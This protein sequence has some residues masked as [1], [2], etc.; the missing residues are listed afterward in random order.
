MKVLIDG[1]EYTKAE[2]KT[3]SIGIAIT[4][5]NRNELVAQTVDKIRKL[6]PNARLV[7]VDDASDKPVEIKEA[8]VYRFKNNVGIAKAK[9]KCLELLSDC[10]HIFLFDDDTYPLVPDWYQPYIGSKEP[11]LMYLFENWAS[12]RPVGDDRI[13]YEDGS[14]VA[15]EHAR[16][17]MIYVDSKVLDVV[18]GMDVRY[19]KAMH[20]HLDWSNRIYNAGLTTFR[21]MDVFNSGKLIYSMD[22][23]QEVKSSIEAIKRRMMAQ[24]NNALLENS[25]TSTE[26]APYG[27]NIVLTSYF[28]G[29]IDPQ[30][31]QRW[32][33]DI[34]AI[35]KLKTSTEAHGVEFA[36][37]HNC[38]DL[39]NMTS[40][41]GSPYFERWLK[42]WQYLRDNPQVDMVFVT[43]ATDVDMLNNPFTHMKPG[44]LYV[45]DEPLQDLTNKWM[46]NNHKEQKVRK[47]MEKHPSLQLLN[48]GV[49]GGDRQ[50][51]MELCRYMYQYYFENPT[52]KTDMGAFNYIVHTKFA[53]RFEYGRHVTTLFKRFEP[54]SSA[55]FRHK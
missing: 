24:T 33:A 51:V 47:F 55:W 18:G 31:N 49:V 3:Y 54:S 2:T 22:Q 45:G 14:T 28:A 20:E 5:H 41:S 48:C 36:L 8:Q 39:P 7:V 40:I 26:Y 9:N 16:G 34:S 35:D 53:D 11:H 50:T 25:Y 23:H 42:Q 6:T 1:D 37:L 30:R 46:L 21:Y 27:S 43:D 44:I 38:F 32:T 4:T 13:V 15:H 29:V 17:C 19:G 12:G 52:E 10:Q